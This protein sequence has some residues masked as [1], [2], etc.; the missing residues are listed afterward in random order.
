MIGNYVSLF[1]IIERVQRLLPTFVQINISDAKEWT[2][3]AIRTIG[4]RYTNIPEVLELTVEN[5]RCKVPSY[6]EAVRG[7]SCNNIPL[8]YTPILNPALMYQYTIV[9][10]YIYSDIQSGTI[11]VYISIFPMDNDG[12]P[13]IPDLGYYVK[14]VTHYIAERLAFKLYLED[15]L[16]ERKYNLLQQEWIF[17]CGSAKASSLMLSESEEA[18]FTNHTMRVIPKMHRGIQV[19]KTTR[20]IPKTDMSNLNDLIVTQQP[21]GYGLPS[22]NND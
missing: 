6:V 7:V 1:D 5:G 21:V 12:N 19:V 11:L 22:T 14:A 3:E 13:L 16:T 20:N 18:D 17:Y 8:T 15:K 9:Q 2:Y 10:G 4:G